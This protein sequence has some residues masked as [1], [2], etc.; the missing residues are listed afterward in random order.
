MKL[1][2]LLAFI[3]GIAFCALVSETF[4]EL[5]HTTSTIFAIGNFV[6]GVIVGF[7][8]LALIYRA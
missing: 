1:Y 2:L 4:P 8:F 7:V 3:L 6:L 5:G